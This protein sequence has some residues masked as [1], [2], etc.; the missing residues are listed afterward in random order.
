MEYLKKAKPV[1]RQRASS[2]LARCAHY[3]ANC[4]PNL[5]QS[6]NVSKLPLGSLR[7]LYCEL[8]S[9]SPAVAK[10]EQ[11]PTWLVAPIISTKTDIFNEMICFSGKV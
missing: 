8:R 9:Q 2:H 10:C 3:I 5:L 1:D 4:V 6:P 7:P 11:A